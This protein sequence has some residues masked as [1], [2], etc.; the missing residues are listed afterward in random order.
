MT[1]SESHSHATHGLPVIVN[2][3]MS[4]L[5]IRPL[6][7]IQSPVRICQPVSESVSS[8]P[9]PVVDQNRTRI[10]SRKARSESVGVS[11]PSQPVKL[12]ESLASLFSTTVET[13]TLPSAHSL[14]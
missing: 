3:K 12:A 9:T 13:T 7:K 1:M 14:L 5:G 4:A 8:H 10:G 2:E 6:V 11:G